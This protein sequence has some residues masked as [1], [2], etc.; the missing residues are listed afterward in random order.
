M[1][2]E[3]SLTAEQVEV[4]CEKIES[5]MSIDEHLGKQIIYVKEEEKISF[6]QDP[7]II[8]KNLKVI[9]DRLFEC[10]DNQISTVKERI[11]M[12]QFSEAYTQIQKMKQLFGIIEGTQIGSSN[13]DLKQIT[14]DKKVVIDETKALLNSGIKA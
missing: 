7:E 11:K 1:I 13:T 8:D 9:F 5:L 3:Q 14:S 4:F 12:L 10:L 2:M 6:F